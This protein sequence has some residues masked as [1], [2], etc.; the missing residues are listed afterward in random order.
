MFAD[1]DKMLTFCFYK[2]HNM[3]VEFKENK[4]CLQLIN[5]R[6]QYFY[7]R[8]SEELLDKI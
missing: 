6:V 8:Q 5:L 3:F 4:D 2:H 7:Y 1:K